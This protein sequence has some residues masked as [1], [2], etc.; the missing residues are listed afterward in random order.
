M[1]P[2]TVQKLEKDEFP[3]DVNTQL[4]NWISV[5][6]AEKSNKYWCWTVHSRQLCFVPSRDV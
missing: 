6:S 3:C 4:Q 1:D 5:W 2:Q